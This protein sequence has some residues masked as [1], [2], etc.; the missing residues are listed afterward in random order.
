MD[1]QLAQQAVFLQ[2]HRLAQDA[3]HIDNQVFIFRRHIDFHFDQPGGP[4]ADPFGAPAFGRGHGRH[5][6]VTMGG[7]LAWRMARAAASLA[8]S[9]C[10]FKMAFSAVRVR[11]SFSNCSFNSGPLKRWPGRIVVISDWVI[12]V[13][14]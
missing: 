9:S 8:P 10:S 5:R 7:F 12:I 4:V 3:R 1:G 2:E 13:S 6:G 14:R 11:Q